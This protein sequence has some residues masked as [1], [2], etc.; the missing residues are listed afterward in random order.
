MTFF[1]AFLALFAALWLFFFTTGPRLERLL[2]RLAHFTANFRY[3]DYVPVFV[4]LAI[5]LGGAIVAG[6]AFIDV[7][8]SVQANSPALQAL[9]A[10]VHRWARATHTTGATVFFTAVTLIGTPAGLGVIGL[11]ACA[12]LA[13]QGRWRWIAYFV[14]TTGAGGLLNLQLKAWFARDRPELAEAL[15]GAHGYSFPSGHAMGATI[16][17]GALAYLAFR[18]FRRWRWRAAAL[19]LGA[20]MTIAISASRVYLGVHWISDVGAGI[21][22]G[23]IWLAG[24]TVAYEVFRRISAVRA[25][26]KREP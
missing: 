19:A 23:W 10:G 24:T 14:V 4:V 26:A 17:F 2:A 6:D 20:S 5:G 16:V 13:A 22:A 8:E 1:L 18:A 3:R 15:R 7:A 11:V 12:A 9:D 21:A 25:R